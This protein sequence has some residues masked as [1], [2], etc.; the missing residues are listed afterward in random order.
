M[1]RYQ[2]LM[3]S[4][5]RARILSAQKSKTR[6]ACAVIN[7]LLSGVPRRKRPD[8]P[9]RQA[10]LAARPIKKK[11]RAPV[12]SSLGFMHQRLVC[13]DSTRPVED[14]VVGPLIRS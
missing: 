3:G 13:Q 14:F 8:D 1:F 7:R 10:G 9:T 12:C 5:L 2:A 4:R 11:A 6:I